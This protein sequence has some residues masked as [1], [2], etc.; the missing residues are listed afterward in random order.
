MSH[1]VRSAAPPPGIAPLVPL[2]VTPGRALIFAGILPPDHPIQLAEAVAR[3]QISRS[4]FPFRMLPVSNAKTTRLV[5]IEDVRAW[6]FQ[7]AEA[8]ECT[9]ASE[10]STR[11]KS[12]RKEACNG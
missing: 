5:L 1:A 2:A 8:Q 6:L 7:R 11:R 3:A 12:L 4:T 9:D 10:S